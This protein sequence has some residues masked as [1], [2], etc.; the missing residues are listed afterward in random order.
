MQDI[1]NGVIG[2]TLREYILSSSLIPLPKGVDGVR[3]IA[4]GEQIKRA[5][6]AWMNTIILA[7]ARLACSP[8]QF[9]L[10]TPGGC[11]NVAVAIQ[12][13]LSNDKTHRTTAFTTDI[14]N[15][16]NAKSRARILSEIYNTPELKPCWNLVNWTYGSE[17]KLRLSTGHC[18]VSRNGVKQGETLG[19]LMFAVSMR[20]IYEEAANVHRDTVRLFCV[21]DDA[22]FVGRAQ[23]VIDCV[24]RFNELLTREHLHLNWSKCQLLSHPSN[25]LPQTT[26][27]FLSQHRVPIVTDATM[28]LGAPIG[29]DDNKRLRLLEEIAAELDPMFDMLMHDS[30]PVQE[31]MGLLRYCLLPSLGYLQRIVPSVYCCK[32]HKVSTAKSWLSQSTNSAFQLNLPRRTAPTNSTQDQTWWIWPYFCCAN[33]TN[34][35]H[36]SRRDICQGSRLNHSFSATS[37]SNQAPHSVKTPPTQSTALG[38]SC[39]FRKLLP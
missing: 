28:L 5:A 1:C 36:S 29:W 38:S 11:E 21:M 6:D 13:M 37:A 7:P 9:G 26:I 31:T 12:A 19:S 18:I 35:T 23:D 32:W 14:S 25:V 30:L 17:S 16:F 34:R 27:D 10:G 24:T 33:V 2:D 39:T 3:P 8:H 4:I 20:R 22:T 15:A